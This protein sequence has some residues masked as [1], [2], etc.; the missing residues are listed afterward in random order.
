[1]L[2]IGTSN[3]VTKGD[4]NSRAVGSKRRDSRRPVRP[5]TC[6]KKPKTK[7][8]ATFRIPEQDKTIGMWRKAGRGGTH[9]AI[10]VAVG[11]VIM[12]S[13]SFVAPSTLAI[14][15]PSERLCDKNK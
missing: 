11:V 15:A 2:A 12:V 9:V 1:M 6:P 4:G 13:F 8:I 14:T 10:L 7:V 3:T 5:R